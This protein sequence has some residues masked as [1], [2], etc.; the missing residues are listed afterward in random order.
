MVNATRTGPQ[1]GVSPSSNRSKLKCTLARAC[2][3]ALTMRLRELSVYRRHCCSVFFSLPLS[4]HKSVRLC[5]HTWFLL[6]RDRRLKHLH[7][8]KIKAMHAAMHHARF[9]WVRSK[10]DSCTEEA[11]MDHGPMSRVMRE[12]GGQRFMQ[13]LEKRITDLPQTG[14]GSLPGHRCA[15]TDASRER[16]DSAV[17]SPNIRARQMNRSIIGPI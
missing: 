17:R 9:S 16:A 10:V 6:K 11:C 3:H 12:K 5:S 8:N 14:M 13:I 7:Y 15:P 4:M 1:L 2:S